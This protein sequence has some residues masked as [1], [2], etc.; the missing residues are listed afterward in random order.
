MI[1]QTTPITSQTNYLSINLQPQQPSIS[2]LI[3]QLASKIHKPVPQYQAQ[4]TSTSNPGF[5][6][7]K[8]QKSQCLPSAGSIAISPLTKK[9]VHANSLPVK[10]FPS[11]QPSSPQQDSLATLNNLIEL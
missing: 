10:S 4:K 2:S 6:P 11:F 5:V 9:L 7:F 1:S 8:R 3:R